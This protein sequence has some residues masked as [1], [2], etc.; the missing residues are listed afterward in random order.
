VAIR[1]LVGHGV[2]E[3][4]DRVA[5]GDPVAGEVQRGVEVREL[6]GPPSGE[7]REG[8]APQRPPAQQ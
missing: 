7:D 4:L 6:H 5:A 8:G 1:H 3:G 2:G